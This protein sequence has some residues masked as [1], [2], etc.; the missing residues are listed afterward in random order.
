MIDVF[1]WTVKSPESMITAAMLLPQTAEY[2]LRAM[3][4]V[5]VL[6]AGEGVRAQ[7]L[8]ERSGIPLPY[9]SKVLRKLVLAGLL[10]SRK[11]HHGGFT[12]ARA[13]RQIRFLDVLEAVEYQNDPDACAFGWRACNPVRPCPLHPA[14]SELK[15]SFKQWGA[16]TTLADIA[17]ANPVPVRERPLPVRTRRRPA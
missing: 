1:Q 4:C 10:T 7:D 14:W 3:A 2:A 5:A 17:V 8:A 13:P 11:G 15:L 16:H 9:L 12:L 6:P